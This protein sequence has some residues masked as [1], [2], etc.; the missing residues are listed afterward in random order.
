[1]AIQFSIL[2][3]GYL[4]TLGWFSFIGCLVVVC[5]WIKRHFNF[6]L[7]L[8]FL[9]PFFYFHLLIKEFLFY[10]QLGTIFPFFNNHPELL[11]LTCV[12]IKCVM[13]YIPIRTLYYLDTDQVRCNNDNKSKYTFL[14]IEEL[15]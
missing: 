15:I 7:F 8:L 3:S 9:Y 11:I 14:K 6:Y 2:F 12:H 5:H 13:F 4:V 1:M 10:L